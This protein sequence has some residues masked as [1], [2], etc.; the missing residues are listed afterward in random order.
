MKYRTLGR[1]NLSVSEI[2]LG[3]W[4]LGG[5]VRV[6]NR[7]SRNADPCGY[8]EV[9]EEDGIAIVQRA[10]SLGI[11]FID[12]APIY[13]DGASE[14]R[15]CRALAGNG[16]SDI[17]VSTKCGVYADNG[18]YVRRFTRDVVLRE[19]EK[20]LRRLGKDV[21]DIEMLHS[22][23]I[24]EFGDGDGWR[25]LLELKEQGVVRFV[26]ISIFSEVEQAREFVESG[27]CDVMM[28]KLNLLD[29]TMLPILDL[30]QR[31]N[32]GIM[33]RE[34]LAGGF[35][36]GLFDENTQFGPDDQRSC[37]P[38]E[39]VLD[40]IRRADKLK[41][42]VRWDRTLAQAAIK[43]V[44]SLPG[45]STVTAGCGTIAELQ[46]NAAVSDMPPLTSAEMD[47]ISGIIHAI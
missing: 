10:L 17:I 32:V 3:A 45:V 23:T 29:L 15:V 37:W 12:T 5:I 7:T 14:A 35:L 13:G 4:S 40:S 9:A 31:H 39:Q 18:Q 16:R 24:A 11:N 19:V 43:W 30:A 25:A 36:T 20:S 47:H 34:S 38:P 8:G 33:V 2:S 21:L 41:F 46:E 6:K 22:P 44:L 26:G 1:T 42:L 27:L 28:L